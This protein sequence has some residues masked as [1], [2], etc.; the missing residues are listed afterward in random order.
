MSAPICSLAMQL[1]GAAP[2]APEV[3]VVHAP[4]ALLPAPFPAASFRKAAEA[5]T[6]FNTLIA[7]VAADGAY[8][9]QT[10]APAAEYDDFTVR[11]TWMSL[12]SFQMSPHVLCT[13]AKVTHQGSWSRL[14]LWAYRLSHALHAHSPFR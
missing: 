10:L 9:Q 1:V 4:L 2:P 7:A 6:A 12:R 13:C 11:R 14:V 8:L 5:A 3:A